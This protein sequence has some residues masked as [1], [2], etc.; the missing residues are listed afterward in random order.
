MAAGGAIDYAIGCSDQKPCRDLEDHNQA[1]RVMI[2]TTMVPQLVEQ[3]PMIFLVVDMQ[4][5]LM[6]DG[7]YSYQNRLHENSAEEVGDTPHDAEVKTTLDDCFPYP[8]L[9]LLSLR[10]RPRAQIIELCIRFHLW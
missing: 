1:N 7:S 5:K 2:E 9:W 8:L 3:H 10:S 4:N 6:I